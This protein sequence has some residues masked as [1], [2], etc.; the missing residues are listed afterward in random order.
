MSPESP[1]IS[2]QTWASATDPAICRQR[3]EQ[4]KRADRDTDTGRGKERECESNSAQTVE[5]MKERSL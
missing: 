2:S 3:K 5:A 1:G 4:R